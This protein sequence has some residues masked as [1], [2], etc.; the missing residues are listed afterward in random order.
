MSKI[1]LGKCGKQVDWADYS[2]N[3]IIGCKQGC[4]YCY[5]KK[6]NDRYKFVQNWNEPKLTKRFYEM[7][8]IN[9]NLKIPKD[10]KPMAQAISPDRPIVFVG[11]MTDIFGNWVDDLEIKRIMQKQIGESVI[12]RTMRKCSEYPN[13]LFLF[14][15]KNVAGIYEFEKRYIKPKNV[16]LGA[17]ITDTWGYIDVD[18]LSIEPLLGAFNFPI[19]D[20]RIKFVIVG[21]MTGANAIEPKKEWIESIKHPTIYWKDN[22][23]K[24]LGE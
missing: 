3:P 2:W 7:D 14:L 16:L 15:S 6:L 8:N 19:P 4:S 9:F 13:I 21:A 5:A 18:F 22:I 1:Q 24:Y 23:K 17:T 10:R 12:E 20:H 11:D